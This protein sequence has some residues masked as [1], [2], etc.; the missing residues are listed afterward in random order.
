MVNIYKSP[1]PATFTDGI[2]TRRD[3][4]STGPQLRSE[5]IITRVFS[6]I[7]VSRT[8]QSCAG[9]FPFYSFLGTNVRYLLILLNTNLKRVDSRFRPR[10]NSLYVQTN[11][12]A[13]FQKEWYR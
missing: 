8:G 11:T 10:A 13:S 3:E 2:D 12:D 6:R 1:R 5:C 4:S 7:G 9:L